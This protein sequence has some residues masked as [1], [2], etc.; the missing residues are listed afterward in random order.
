MEKRLFLAVGLSL[1]VV[2]VFQAFFPSKSP[3]VLPAQT[4]VNSTGFSKE[5]SSSPVS[6]ELPAAEVLQKTDFTLETYKATAGN[7]NFEVSNNGGSISS[8]YLNDYKYHFPVNGLADINTFHGKP[9]SYIVN[10]KSSFSLL[11]K[12]RDLTVE[13]IVSVKDYTINIKYKITN[14]TEV[15]RS[16]ELQTKP[17][18]LDL[19]RLDINVLKSEWTLFEYSFKTENKIERKEQVNNF[20]EK[21][22]KEESKKLDWMAFRDRY[23]V[24]I[25]E[26]QGSFKGYTTKAIGKNELV[27][28]AELPALT[29]QPKATESYS[30]TVYCGP[31]KLNLLKEAKPGFE[32]VL[33]FSSW[34]WLDLIA[35]GIYWALGAVHKI[36]PIWGLCII[37]VSLLVYGGMY[38]LTLK[39]M[40]SM[41]KMQALQPKMTQ[42]KEKYKDNAEKLNKEIVELYRINNV[43]PVSG[44]LPMLLQMP[45]FVGLYQVLWRSVYFRGESFLWIKDL[46]MPDHL[47][48]MPVTVPFLGDYFNILPVLMMIIMFAQQAITL[49]NSVGGDPEQ[50]QQQKMMAVFMPILLGV[51]FYNFA[52]GL[53][54]YFVVF[55][56]LSALSQWNISKDL[57]AT[58]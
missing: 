40:M 54:L 14:N 19:S 48:K 21:W 49:K 20:S 33:V 34:G 31:Q 12:D 58:V 39:S 4:T 3:K 15:A 35:K 45:I 26:P 51:M 42:L 28:S 8:V 18:D 50:V 17:F 6:A 32:K 2:F 53:N 29:V 52:S 44:C 57:K 55:Y 5:S 7:F 16:I 27:F 9:F 30:F 23:F 41:K 37:V 43:N 22:N 47:I 10:S 38:P 46:S 25:V 24:T 36:L 13:K 11:F 1:L 56:S